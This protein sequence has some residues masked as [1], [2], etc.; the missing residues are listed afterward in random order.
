[1]IDTIILTLPANH[2]YITEHQRFSP[3][4]AGLFQAPYYPLGKNG[5][6]KCFQNPRIDDIKKGV[7]RPRLTAIRRITDLGYQ[8]VLKI[9]FSI[10]KLVFGNNFDEVSNT[11]FEDIVTVLYSRLYEWELLFP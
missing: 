3:S 7:Y 2:F 9:E 6:F 4:T 5:F 1:M 10:P 11:D 8:T